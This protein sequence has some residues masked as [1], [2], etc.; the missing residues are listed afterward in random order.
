MPSPSEAGAHPRAGLRRLLWRLHFWAGLVTAPLLLFA[1]LTGLLYVFTPQVEAWRHAHLDRVVPEGPVQPLDAQRAAAE[2]SVPGWTLASV[3]P[4]AT[5][6]ASSQ[7][8]FRRPQ[9]DDVPGAHAGHAAGLPAG[10]IAYVDPYRA[11]V[12]G[13]LDEPQRFRHWARKLHANAL[14]GE[15]WRWPIELAASWALVMLATGL[16][17]AWPSLRAHGWRALA[18][19]RNGWRGAHLAFGLVFGGVLVVLLVTGLTWSRHA[20]DHFRTALK[21]TGQTAPRPPATLRSDPTGAPAPLALQDAYG[22]ARAAA[23][24]LALQLTPPHGASGTW[25]IDAAQGVPGAGPG[26]R[27]TLVLDAYD[28]RPL[29]RSGWAELPPLAKATALGIPFHRGEFGLWNQVL[30]VLTALGLVGSLVSGLAMAWRRRAR[31]APQL[32]PGTWR[33]LP[34]GLWL[35]AGLLALALPVFG[36]SLLVYAAGECLAAAIGRRRLAA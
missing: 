28:G 2:A 5:P 31:G 29:Y 7:F 16:V 30:L 12:V 20:G 24:G 18:P 36:L 34:R 13:L 4:A 3:I 35:S 8:L 14:Q 21:L 15:A 1:A 22:I 27:L 32:A 26:E 6:D 25:R 23:P 19:A 17:L 9:G 10:R 33:R 11:E